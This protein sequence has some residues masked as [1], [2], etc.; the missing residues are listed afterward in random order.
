MGCEPLVE[1]DPGEAGV[2]AAA[3]WFFTRAVAPGVWLIAEPQHVYTWLVAG[4]DRAAIL[5]TGM[6]VLP[7]RPVAESLTPLPVMVV[8]THSHFD[9]IGG[10]HEFSEIAI[11]ELGAPLID[12]PVP[13]DLLQ[14][15]L[16][17]VDRQL[18]AAEAY[19]RLDREYFW[20]LTPES[21]PRPLPQGFD[22]GGWAIPGT[23]ATTR[24]VDGDRVDLG[25]RELTVIFA[26]GHSPDGICLLDEHAGFLFGGDTVNA[27]PIY[28]H[29]PDSDIDVLA[30]SAQRL[31]GMEDAVDVAVFH[32][33]PRPVAEPGLL[34]EFAQGIGAVAAGEVPLVKGRDVLDGPLLEARFDHFTVSVADSEA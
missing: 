17:Y 14:A 34:R 18:A 24:L 32:H 31:A 8:N 2:S 26:P 23:T 25:G 6:G 27:G 12:Q 5:D 30:Q 11:H 21:D 29:F 3:D 15:Y 19:R 9:H 22:R 10:N 28:A 16:G 7:I 20:L 1:R 33:Y 13:G 4:D